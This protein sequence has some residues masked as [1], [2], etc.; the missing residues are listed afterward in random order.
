MNNEEF[1]VKYLHMHKSGFLPASFAGVA[2]AS[3]N[4]ATTAFFTR[5][6]P[7]QLIVG[8]FWGFLRKTGIF[9]SFFRTRGLLRTFFVGKIPVFRR[10]PQKSPTIKC[11]GSIE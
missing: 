2:T 10:N 11:R 6:K 1:L 4:R 8:D 7:R 3:C 9:P 5:E